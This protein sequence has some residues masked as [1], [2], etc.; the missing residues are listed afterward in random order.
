MDEARIL[1]LLLCQDAM[2]LAIAS[3]QLYQRSRRRIGMRSTR[4]DFY[5][6]LSFFFLI[7]VFVSE[8]RPVSTR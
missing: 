5:F 3:L 1:A 8:I 7:R 2:Q 6:I 4:R